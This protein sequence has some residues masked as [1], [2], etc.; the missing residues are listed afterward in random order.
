MKGL[1]K[2]LPLLTALL[3]IGLPQTAFVGHRARGSYGTSI[4]RIERTSLLSVSYEAERERELVTRANASV[5]RTAKSEADSISRVLI[6][7]QGRYQG[8][9]LTTSLADTLEPCC[10]STAT[11]RVTQNCLYSAAFP[12]PPGYVITVEI[13]FKELPSKDILDTLN[14]RIAQKV[15]QRNSYLSYMNARMKKRKKWYEVWK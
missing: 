4:F 2:R 6:S 10:D 7:M 15:L 1:N 8:R 11:N 9:F 13:A 12:D 3:V 14:M 5:E